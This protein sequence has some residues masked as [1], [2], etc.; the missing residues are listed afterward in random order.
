MLPQGS[1]A[2]KCGMNWRKS[3]N[4]SPC[5]PTRRTVYANLLISFMAISEAIDA[6]HFIRLSP[7][8]ADLYVQRGESCYF[9]NRNAKAIADLTRSVELQ[10]NN[11][12]SY[13]LQSLAFWTAS[14]KRNRLKSGRRPGQPNSS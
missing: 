9:L 6:R 12:R 14:A 5:G 8:Q 11:A 2:A 1:F 3:T 13:M 4:A 10:P 7:K